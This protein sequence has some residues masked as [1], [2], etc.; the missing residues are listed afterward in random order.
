LEA[1]ICSSFPITR[2][3]IKLMIDGTPSKPFSA[4]TDVPGPKIRLESNIVTGRYA[5]EGAPV[6]IVLRAANA[7]C[8]NCIP[9][10]LK[11]M[12]SQNCKRKQGKVS[13][14]SET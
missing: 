7:I 10:I 14:E 13:N 2:A 1:W 8:E 12:K 11:N 3:Y 5:R 9:V 4:A 6:R